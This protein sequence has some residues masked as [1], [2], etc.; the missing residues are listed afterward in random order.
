MLSLPATRTEHRSST[1]DSDRDPLYRYHQ[2]QGNL[3]I[4]GVSEIKT[5]PYVPLSH[6]F[7]ERLVGTIRRECLDQSLFWTATDLEL[8]YWPSKTTTTD[9]EFTLRLRERL[10]SKRRHPRALISNCIAGRNIVC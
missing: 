9:A 8:K 3:R 7:I 4:L 5:V 10:R 2:W 6:P 1:S